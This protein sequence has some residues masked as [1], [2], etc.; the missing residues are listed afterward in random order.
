MVGPRSC[1]KTRLLSQV[2]AQHYRVPEQAAS[3]Q[4]P[5]W[6]DGREAQL[7]SPSSMADELRRSIKDGSL[8]GALKRILPSFVPESI[9]VEVPG[10]K[11]EFSPEPKR[12]PDVTV[13]GAVRMA[14]ELFEAFKNG[15]APGDPWP[16]LVL[17]EAN[18]MQRWSAQSEPMLSDRQ[19]IMA[20]L[21]Q[22]RQWGGKAKHQAGR[23]LPSPACPHAHAYAA[24]C[25]CLR[26]CLARQPTCYRENPCTAANA[27]LPW[28]P[29][30]V[31]SMDAAPSVSHVSSY[32][33]LLACCQELSSPV[34]QLRLL[35][36]LL[37]LHCRQQR[38]AGMPT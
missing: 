33:L 14:K 8:P 15:K 19:A 30:C 36:V 38:S 23:T 21:V 34:S 27:A 6:L 29:M 2:A 22:V 11:A 20:F 4:L 17:D 10:V 3:L 28:L 25:S 35:F 5:G 7:S 24:S 12:E 13:V 31:Q 16:L 32:L 26:V 9:T 1:G 18:V 37:H